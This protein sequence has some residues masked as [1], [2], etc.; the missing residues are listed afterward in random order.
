[1]SRWGSQ[2]TQISRNLDTT[3]K[4]KKDIKKQE[5]PRHKHIPCDH[6]IDTRASMFL[7]L[8][9]AKATWVIVGNG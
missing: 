1:M 9:D 6:I 8:A 4:K 7:F 3:K 2:K 5:I